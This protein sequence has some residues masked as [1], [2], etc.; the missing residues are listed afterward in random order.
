MTWKVTERG[1]RTRHAYMLE[2]LKPQS[3]IDQISDYY[4][5]DAELEKYPFLGTAPPLTKWV[6]NR[7]EIAPAE[8]TI[9][10]RNELYEG[11]QKIP[12]ELIWR[13]KIEAVQKLID[14]LARRNVENWLDLLLELVIAGESKSTWDG[15]FFFDTDHSSRASGTQDNDIT[16]D[17]TTPTAPSVAEVANALI[18]T[19]AQ[20]M[21]FKDDHGKPMNEQA[22]EFL[23]ISNSTLLPT[24]G[25]AVG[26]QMIQGSGGAIDNPLSAFSGFKLRFFS[27]P[28]ITWTNA[29]LAIFR[30]DGPTK[31]LI[32]QE[33]IAVD[34]G[35]D[36]LGEG[37]DH[38][39]KQKEWLVGVKAS[40]AVA[41]GN[42]QNA[43]LHT[44][45]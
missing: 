4:P 23:V 12:L 16:T 26:N 11:T 15:Q 39:F 3:W 33:E 10:V 17:I 41:Y 42:W 40:R 36:I 19:I 27:T 38:A 2:T 30:I 13:D 20:I 18:K 22:Q 37:S 31:A 1:I 5:S 29:L 8:Y 32:R 25:V 34:D 24:L 35:I 9:E 21:G 6:T 43:C 28:R 14:G 44:F 45:V 7:S